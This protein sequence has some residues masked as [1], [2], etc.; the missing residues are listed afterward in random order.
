M[1]EK[2]FKKSIIAVAIAMI[3][4]IVISAVV[5]TMQKIGNKGEQVSSSTEAANIEVAEVK[6]ASTKIA[7]N[8]STNPDYTSSQIPSG[9][10]AKYADVMGEIA[11]DGSWQTGWTYRNGYCL[12]KG[13]SLFEGSQL[14]NSGDAYSRV[15]SQLKW[16]FD[17]MI[18]VFPYNLD[19]FNEQKARVQAKFGIDLSGL[20]RYQVF[21][22]QQCA[23]WYFTNELNTDFSGQQKDY[24]NALINGAQ[25]SYSSDG[26]VTVTANYGNARLLQ[27]T[28][29]RRAEYGPITISNPKNVAYKFSYS[30]FTMD[31]TARNVRVLRSDTGAE[32]PNNSYTTFSGNLYVIVDGFTMGRANHEYELKGNLSFNTYKTDSIYWAASG[33]QSVSTFTRSP[34]TNTISVVGKFKKE[35]RGQFNLNITKTDSDDNN[36]LGSTIKARKGIYTGN[37][38]TNISEIGEQ[39]GAIVTANDNMIE[40]KNKQQIIEISEITAPTGY[41]KL[42]KNI[43]AVLSFKEDGD[44]YVIDNVKIKTTNNNTQLED[45]TTI[46]S[47]DGTITELG[48]EVRID[49]GTGNIFSVTLTSDSKLDVKIVNLKVDLALKK[50]ITRV[51]RAG[52]S[53]FVNVTEENCNVGRHSGWAINT[54]SL[55]NSTN[56]LY[57][58][59]KTPVRVGKGDE[60]E[61]AIKI[62]NEGE[63]DGYAK[64]IYDYIPTGLEV[65]GVTYKNENNEPI[66][67][68]NNANSGAYATISENSNGALR[69]VFPNE[70]FI[71]AY[72]KTNKVLSSDV[73]YVTCRVK[74]DATGILTNVAEI[75]LYEFRN[76]GTLS[77]D[78]DSTANNWHHWNPSE[79]DKMTCDKGTE[80]WRKYCNYQDVLLDGKWHD[81]FSAQDTSISGK[82]GDD[83]DFDKLEVINVDLA[84]KKIITNVTGVSNIKRSSS[85]D[86]SSWV[87]TTPLAN[88]QTDALYNMNK[89]PILAKKGSEVT[90]RL[91]IFN[92]GTIDAKAAEIKDYIPVGLTVTGVYY[93]DNQSISEVLSGNFDGSNEKAYY[94]DRQ[95][96]VLKINLGITDNI[97][98]KRK[99]DCSEI[100]YDYV[101]VK[102]VINEQAENI[103]TNVAEISK[104]SDGNFVFSQDIDSFS[105][106]WKGV[107]DNPDGDS[108][109]NN[110]WKTYL[111]HINGTVEGA[112]DLDDNFHTDFK[113]S[114]YS[115]DGEEDDDDFEKVTVLDD[116]KVVVQKQSS[117]NENNKLEGVEFYI[118]Q[119][120]YS[121]AVSQSVER[122]SIKATNSEGKTEPIEKDLTFKVNEDEED[123]FYI[124]EVKVPENSTYSMINSE[125]ELRISKTMYQETR[126]VN[127]QA[128]CLTKVGDRVDYS[129]KFVTVKDVNGHNVIVEVEYDNA[130]KT[131]IITVP[132]NISNSN[133]KLKLLKTKAGTGTPITGVKF[134]IN[135]KQEPLTTDGNGKID[136]G[137]YEIT[138]DNYND[139]DE[140]IISEIED[141]SSRYLQLKNPIN[142]KVK[143]AL[144][145]TQENYIVSGISLNNSTYSTEKIE[146]QVELKNSTKKVKLSAEIQGNTVYVSVE[147][148]EK[149]GQYS[150][151]V[152]KTKANG[153]VLKTPQTGF[154]LSNISNQVLTDAQTGTALLVNAKPIT[155][156]T[157]NADTYTITET[158]APTGFAKLRYPIT[159][160]VNKQDNGENFEI[161]SVTVSVNNGQGV[162]VLKGNYGTLSNVELEDGSKIN[163]NI[164]LQ[165]NNQI[166]IVVPN[167]E[168]TGKYNIQ[169]YKYSVKNGEQIP[170]S[171]IGFF[172]RLT[173]ITGVLK[174]S[175]RTTGADGLANITNIAIEKAG[176]DSYEI[177]EIYDSESNV[178]GIATPI[179]FNVIK[180][181]NSTGTGYTVSDANFTNGAKTRAVTLVNG[182]SV[183]AVLEVIAGS[184]GVSTIKISIE[185]PQIV[186]RYKVELEKVVKTD[187]GNEAI[188]GVTFKVKENDGRA[189][190]FTTATNGKVF[191]TDK[192]I[193]YENVNTQDKY[194]IDEI[195]LNNNKYIKLRDPLTLQ[196]TKG[197]NTTGNV[198]EEGAPGTK[199]VVQQFTLSGY[200][201]SSAKSSNGSQDNKQIALTDIVL[202][203]GS[204]VDITAKLTIENDVLT[205]EK[206]EKVSITVP[207]KERKG[208]YSVKVK[209]VNA[210]KNSA[211]ISN[212]TFNV[213]K[214]INGNINNEYVTDRTGSNGEISLGNVTMTADTIDTVD[215]FKISEVKI[216]KSSGNEEETGFAKLANPLILSVNKKVNVNNF[217]VEKLTLTEQ[218]KAPVE[219]TTSVTL[220]NV[221]LENGETVNV[222]ASIDSDN[223]ITVVI[224]NKELG[225]SYS[226]DLVKTTD[227]FTNPLADINFK[228]T[229]ND[230][231]EKTDSNGLI[232]IVRNKQITK[233][234]V[235]NADTY[236]I[237]EIEDKTN[238]YLELA[239][240]LDVKVEKVKENNKFVVSKITL[241]SGGRNAV[242]NANSEPSVVTLDNIDTVNQNRKTSAKLEFNKTTQKITVTVDNP[243]LDGQYGL[244]ILKVDS[245][246]AATK[247]D[248]VVFNAKKYELNDSNQ[249]EVTADKTETTG[250]NGYAYI[251]G[252]NPLTTL[253]VESSESI[254]KLSPEKWEITET[255]TKENYEILKN[256]VVTLNITKKISDDGKKYVIDTVTPQ[257]TRTQHDSESYQRMKLVRGGLEVTVNQ[258]GTDIEVKIPNRK[259]KGSYSLSLLKVKKASETPISG[260]PFS[261]SKNGEEIITNEK[262][263]AEGVI[264]IGGQTISGVATDEYVV[265]EGNLA[266]NQ[267]IGLNESITVKVNTLENADKTKYVLGSATFND[268]STQKT[269]RT[270]KG[271]TV[272]AKIITD[273]ANNTVKLVVENDEFSGKYSVYLKKVVN[274]QGIKDVVFKVNGNN[275]PATDN[276]GMT[277]VVSDKAITSSTL[278]EDVYTISEINIDTNKYVKLKAPIVLRV[279]K[280][281][282]D[283]NTD[284]VPVSIRLE[285]TGISSEKFEVGK[286]SVELEGIALTND[287]LVTVKA[288]L[289]NNNIVVE[290]PNEEVNGGYSVKIKKVNADKNNAKIPGTTFKVEKTING[291]AQSAVVTEKTNTSAG[292]VQIANVT[293]SADKINQIDTYKVSEVKIYKS[294]DSNEEDTGYLKLVNPV[295]LSVTKGVSG[296]KFVVTN[297]KLEQQ[298]MQAVSGATNATLTGVRLESGRTVNVSASIDNNNVITLTVPNAE[299]NGKYSLDLIKTRNNFTETLI[300]FS[301][302]YTGNLAGKKT[303]LDGLV[304][305]VTDKT[306][307]KDDVDTPDEYEITEVKDSNNYYLEL[308]QPV[309]LKVEKT[310][311]ENT[312]VVNK[313]TISSGERTAT[314][315]KGTNDNTVILN[316]VDTVNENVKTSLKLV[317]DDT[318]NKITAY[319]DNPEVTGEYSLKIKKVDSQDSNR[320]LQ[321][322]T[323]KLTKQQLVEG[324][325]GYVQTKEVTKTTDSSGYAYLLGDDPNTTQVEEK[326]SFASRGEDLIEIT[327]LST[328]SGYDLLKDIKLSLEVKNKI[329]SDGKTK[330]I[331]SVRPLVIPSNYE[332]DTKKRAEMV[333]K[334]LNVFVNEAGTEISITLPNEKTTDYNFKVKKVDSNGDDVT[335]AKFTVID[336][337][338][339]NPEGQKL[340]DNQLLPNNSYFVQSYNDVN[341]NK[342]Y[343][344]SVTENSTPASYINLLNGFNLNVGVKIDEQG[345]VDLDNSTLEIEPQNENYDEVAYGVISDKILHGKIKI[346]TEDDD[347]TLTLTIENPKI[348]TDYSLSLYKSELNKEV[349]L[350]NARFN[351]EKDGEQFKTIRTAK[352]NDSLIDS[353]DGVEINSHFVYEVEETEAPGNLKL[354]YKKVRIEISTD[355]EG[356]VSGGITKVLGREENAEWVDYDESTHGSIVKLIRQNETNKFILKWSDSSRFAFLL[357]KQGYSKT[358]LGKDYTSDLIPSLPILTNVQLGI[359]EDGG[360]E[361]VVGTTTPTIFHK[362]NVNSNSEYTYSIRELSTIAGYNNDFDG[363]KLVVHIRTDEN[364]RLIEANQDMKSQYSYY[365][366]IDSTGNKTQDQLKALEAFIK[367]D[368]NPS[369]DSV[370]FYMVNTAQSTYTDYK[371]QIMKMD[372]DSHK[373]LKDA[374]FE[375]KLDK[376]DGNG[377]TLLDS[378]TNTAEQDNYKT[379]VNG[380]I[381]ISNIPFAQAT[382]EEQIHTFKIK[383]INAPAGYTGLG[384][385]VITVRVNLTNKMSMRDIKPEDVTI[386]GVED[387]DVEYRVDQDGW[388]Y[389]I[390]PNE[391]KSYN[392]RLRKMDTNGNLIVSSVNEQTGE[393]EGTVMDVRAIGKTILYPNTTFDTGELTYTCNIANQNTNTHAYV[394]TEKEAKN[395]YINVLQGYKLTVRALV[396]ENGRVKQINPDDPTDSNYTHYQIARD[397]SS[398]EQP[399]IA[400]EQISSYIKLYISEDSNGG[401]TVCVDVENPVSYMVRLRKTDTKDREIDQAI[402]N[403]CIVNGDEQVEKARIEGNS[404]AETEFVSIRDNETQ[405]WI[406]DELYANGP[407][408]N[409][410][411]DDKKL[412]VTAKVVNG[413]LTYDYAVHDIL[414]GNEVI[415]NKR[416]KIYNYIS[417]NLVKENGQN[418]I[419]VQIKNPVGYIFEVI[420]GDI[421]GHRITEAAIKVNDQTNIKEDGTYDSSVVI[422][423]ENVPIENIET[424][425]ISEIRTNAPYVNVLGDNKLFIKVYVNDEGKVEI[426]G[427]GYIDPEGTSHNGFGEFEQY[428]SIRIIT[429]A[430]TKVQTIEVTLK[431]PSQIRVKL[432]KVDENG[433]SLPGAS[434]Q[435]IDQNG[436]VVENNGEYTID[437][438]TQTERVFYKNFSIREIAAPKGYNNVFNNKELSFRASLSGKTANIGDLFVYELTES[439]R[440]IISRTDPIYE[441][442]SSEVIQGTDTL[443]G[444]P[445]ISFTI[446]NPTDMNLYI[447]K[448]LTNS[449]EYN[450]AELELYSLNTENNERTSIATNITNPETHAKKASIELNN[451]STLPNKTYTYVIKEKSTNAPHVNILE[452][453]EIRLNVKLSKDETTGELGLDSNYDIYDNEGNVLN[454]DS[455]RSYVS[456][457]PVKDE[458]TG[459]YTLKV[460]IKNPS[461]FKMKFAKTDLAGNALNGKAV[462]SINDVQN[463]GTAEESYIM[464]IGDTKTF[465]ISETSISKPFVNAL[466]EN[467][468]IYIMV[469]LMEDETVKIVNTYTTNETGYVGGIDNKYIDYKIVNDE[470]GIPTLDIKLKNPMEYKIRI[471]KQDMSETPLEGAVITAECE[472]VTYSNEGRDYIEIPVKDQK[473]GDETIVTIKEIS[474]KTNFDNIFEDYQ[475]V[476]KFKVKDDYTVASNGTQ[477]F[478][479]SDSGIVTNYEEHSRFFRTN[480]INIDENNPEIIANIF[481]KN[482]VKYDLKVVKEDLAGN[483]LQGEDLKLKVTKNSNNTK[484]NNG[485]SSIVFNE[486]YLSP[487]QENTYEIEELSTIA[488]YANILA[489]KKLTITVKV[490]GDG[491]LVVKDFK[492]MDK[493]TGAEETS[494]YVTYDKNLLSED[495][496]RLIKVVVKNPLS[497]MF[498]V[499]KTDIRDNEINKATISVNDVTNINTSVNP[500]AKTSNVVVNENDVKIGDVKR[501]YIT[502]TDTEKPYINVFGN[503]KLFVDVKMNEMAKL[504]ITNKGYIDESETVHSGFGQFNQYV[505]LKIDTNNQTK[506]QTVNVQ[507][508]NPINYKVKLVKLDENGNNLPNANIQIIHEGMD[509]YSTNG[510]D[511]IEFDVNTENRTDTF[512]INELD[513]AFGYNNNLKG[514]TMR[515]EV[516]NGSGIITTR[517]TLTDSARS[518]WYE[519]NFNSISD[520][521]TYEVKQSSETSDGVPVIEIKMKNT[522][523]YNLN[524]VKQ[525]TNNVAY[526]GAE[527]ELYELNT[528]NNERTLIAKNIDGET[529]LANITKNQIKTLP[530]EEHIYVIK[531]KSTTLPHVNILDDDKEIRVTMKLEKNDTTGKLR[532]N[533]DYNIY[534]KNGNVLA[535]DVARNFIS[536]APS[537]DYN[538]GKY[539]L[540]VY[541]KNP[542]QFRMR[543][544][545]TDTSGNPIT[546]KAVIAINGVQNNGTASE[547][548]TNLKVGDSVHLDVTETSVQD[549]FVNA[550]GNHSLKFDAT[551]MENEQI[552]VQSTIPA[553][554]A[555]Y[556]D[557][558]VVTDNDGVQ[559]LEIKLKNPMK[560]KVKLV[561]QDLAGTGLD[562]TNITVTYNDKV[563]KNNGTQFIEIPVAKEDLSKVD[564]FKIREYS[565][566]T[567]YEN[568]FEGKE[569]Q[570]K[571]KVNNQYK[572]E[573]AEPIKMINLTNSNTTDVP[574]QYFNFGIDNMQNSNEL[575]ANITLKNPIKY[576]LAVIKTDLSG[577]EISGTGLQMKVT[578]N[579]D[580]PKLNQGNST[581]KYEE[582]NLIPNTVNKY[583]VEELSTIAPHI[584]ELENKKLTAEVRVNEIGELVM[585]TFV[586]T[587]KTT[588]ERVA[589]QYVD[590]DLNARSADGTRLVKIFVRNPMSYKFKV[591]KTKTETAQDVANGTIPERLEGASIEVNNNSNV[592]GNSE[593]GLTINDVKV[594]ETKT[595]I[596]KENATVGAHE[597][598][599]ENKEI[600]LTTYMGIDKKL[601]IIEAKLKDTVSNESIEIN[602]K[603]KEQYRFDYEI[604]QGEDGFE[605][606]NV[607]IQNPVKMKMKVV[608]TDAT[609][610]TELAGAEL[611]LKLGNKVVASN[612]STGSSVLDY[613]INNVGRGD[614]FTCTLAENASVSPNEN[615]LNGKKIDISFKLNDSEEME[616]TSV[617]QIDKITGRM[618][619]LSKFVKISRKEI[620]GIQTLLMEVSNPV[621]FDLD[622][623]KNAAGLGFL[624]NTKFQVYREDV[625][626]SLFD[627][628]V[629]DFN[630][631]KT[632]EVSEHKLK[633]GTY[634]YYIT[635]TKSARERYINILE[636]KYIKLNLRVSGTGKVDV[637]DNNGEVSQKYFEVYEGNIADRK[638]TDKLIPNTDLIYSCINLKTLVN[639]E[640]NKYLIHVDVTNPVKYT[641]ELEKVD[642]VQNPLKDAEFEMVSDIINSQNALKTEMNKTVG[643]Q[644]ITADGKI[645]GKTNENGNVSY[646]ETYVMAGTYEYTLK[647]VKTPGNQYVNPFEGYTIHFKVSVN[648]DGDIELVSYENGRNTYIEKD[649][650]EAPEDIYSYL[651]LTRRNNEIIAKLQIE[652][653]NPVRYLVKLDKDVYGEENLPL[654]GAKF[655]IESGLIKN[656]GAEKT[657]MSETVGVTEVTRN[658][659][660]KGTTNA[661]GNISFEETM[662]RPGIYE[663]W[664]SEIETGDQDILNALQG[665]VIKVYLKVTSDGSIY[666]VTDDGQNQIIENGR[667][668]LYD[669]TRQNKIDFDTTSIDELI[670]VY[671]TKENAV[672]TLHVDIDNPQKFDFDLI[673]T[674]IDL[675]NLEGYEDYNMNDVEFDIKAYKENAEH[676]LDEIE[677][678][679]AMD[680]TKSFDLTGLVTSTI[681]DTKGMISLKDILIPSAG[682][683][684]LEFIEKTP[685]TPIIY[686][687]KAE[688]VK[689]K[690]VIGLNEAGNKYEIKSVEPVQGARYVINENTNVEDSLITVNV[691]NERVKGSYNL[692]I[693][694]L[695][696]LLGGPVQGAEFV[697]EAFEGVEDAENDNPE[698]MVKLYKSTDDVTSMD[699]LIPGK[700]TINSEDGIFRINKIRIENLDSYVI[701]ITETKAPETY[702]I[703]RDPVMLKI[704]PKI[705]GEYDDAKFVVDTVEIIGSDND[706]LVRLV[707][708]DETADDEN[709]EDT[710]DKGKKLIYPETKDKIKLEITNNQF[711]LSL[712]KYITS[713]NGKDISRWTKPEIDTSK[714]ITGEETTAEYY[715]NKL[716]LRI[717]TGQ[718]IIYTLRVY[719]EGQIDGYANKIV[720]HLPEQLEFLENDEFNTSRGWKLV[721]G[722]TSMIETDFLSKARNEDEN[723]IKAFDNKTGEIDYKEVQVKCKVKENVEPKTY[724]TNIAEITEFEGK[725]RPNV[726]DRDSNGKNADI[727]N[728]K[729]LQEYKQDEIEKQQTSETQSD[730]YISGQE[731]DDDFEKVLVERFDLALRKFITQVNDKEITTRIPEVTVDEKG[732]V[733]YK[734]DKTPLVVAHENL[735]EY[736]I[737]VYNE[738]TVS[739]YANLV[740][741]DIPAGLVFVPDAETNKQYKWKLLDPSGRET[742]DVSNAKYV[743]TDYLSEENGKVKASDENTELTSEKTENKN[744][745]KYFDSKTMKEPDYRD[746]KVVF[747]VNVPRR[748]DDI[749]INEAQISDDRDDFGEEVDDDDSVTDVWNEG[750]DD[751]D[752]EYIKVKYF[753][754]ALYKWVTEAIVTEDGKTTVHP[755]N[756]TQDD[757]SNMLNVAIKKNKVNDVTV[758]FKYMIKVENQG[759]LSGYAKEIKDHIPAGLKFVAEDN[760]EYGWEEQPDGTITN[761]CFE[762]TLLNEGDTAEVAVILTWINGENNL[763]LKTNYA[764][765]SKDYNDSNSHDID[766]STDNLTDIPREDDEDEDIV[767]LQ[768]RTG[769]PDYAIIAITLLGAMMIV[770]GGVFGIRK[771]VIK[772]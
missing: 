288:T 118:G 360:E 438:L 745:I 198:G 498:K 512:I 740:K 483:E 74:D 119:K 70:K 607:I 129:K 446:K 302:K 636:N 255:S 753:D 103:L 542:L 593:V 423:E 443:D 412:Y 215:T 749:I 128:Y 254:T 132:N 346:D 117:E 36:L 328:T 655:E 5:V 668:Y 34:K 257:V 674:D 677:L 111:K 448:Q 352:N 430:L 210:S 667:F 189:T 611:E 676:E 245:E 680:N 472:G 100:Y 519:N 266:N 66:Q 760:T 482:Q 401:Q 206:Y 335:G 38:V 616:I 32:V 768:I 617:A 678:R 101:T 534:D 665:N 429:N 771:F 172:T 197:K 141:E 182:E 62:F 235:G 304:N 692:E 323:F 58:M 639:N 697:I 427:K 3:L 234:N 612:K 688:N 422:Q 73:V 217:G 258:A 112:N 547:T 19:N 545:K 485:T 476:S 546:G 110:K 180:S 294:V 385:D 390:V 501:F 490:D 713:I 421:S 13:D 45:I 4:T 165:V 748:S 575:I 756:H 277:T 269:V 166:L 94:Y 123:V 695:E 262:T 86:I 722:E 558:K 148:I 242:L 27:N 694:K 435:I 174:G 318:N 146:Q 459:K 309:K 772:A 440:N 455:A 615:I 458:N 367:L 280:G 286:T 307:T 719:N 610:T 404:K 541:I 651:T 416:N 757:K 355:N 92:E 750:E 378:N 326:E 716:P 619:A 164:D 320:V 650:V 196:I 316:N 102:C 630:V 452:N 108:K 386:S 419:D 663:Y 238:N 717:Y 213:T 631:L 253:Q 157:L 431:N 613:T 605:T 600:I 576:D 22:V 769:I 239:N 193:N 225:G 434:L 505:K 526:N 228:Y 670:K 10:Y 273:T 263:N 479:I 556:V 608:K 199:F 264:D 508:I 31:G 496:T 633:A 82:Q 659:V 500:Q 705:E 350:E 527:L 93:K 495:G 626:N 39:S 186:G 711:D 252:D 517:D 297:L 145:N 365:E 728:G 417:V 203:D 77:Q 573:L 133:Y 183:N 236:E 163:V 623:A 462:I 642:S 345:K 564:V 742:T 599:L 383:E 604:V 687:D 737:R 724:I 48:R 47:P 289:T 689:V 736:T 21:E 99:N 240:K 752:R 675:Y 251:S 532:L 195:L 723:V 635:E 176:T 207:N 580:E 64:F 181:L 644:A 229:G 437:Y 574:S 408:S 209:K 596:V 415:Y 188:P 393:K 105:Q 492:V 424:Y 40:D 130:S 276:S 491:E 250:T 453:K 67:I 170:V 44:K 275:L 395:G 478:K 764:E 97:I 314:L 167:N 46:T 270:K 584:N 691:T 484:E 137:E 200:G 502:E 767:M 436:T 371:L 486:R 762:N 657:R 50:M 568:V 131:F 212:V 441:C 134:G 683:Y 464:N 151:M 451:I 548:Y 413:E 410:L 230:N 300:G 205:N 739:G 37:G 759:N 409:V 299:V 621:G 154:S 291:T 714:L 290:I 730:K 524:I 732:K 278:A 603:V 81:S 243:A 29:S 268:G 661:Q 127:M 520:Y 159:V 570:V 218:G 727:P 704:T 656:Q 369:A 311:E 312:Y 536:L 643:V 734:H 282:N 208:N 693:L 339:E 735:V 525:T 632:A 673:K 191:I 190:S 152:K 585:Q 406:I 359:S 469:R 23:V 184:N 351:V 220:N 72:D 272:N 96:N 606:V 487:L 684:Y 136:F 595:F 296:D 392:F 227:N 374:E 63:I 590:Y 399:V 347:K 115:I 702:T 481:L 645:T 581:I 341:I 400:R 28:N 11:I 61:Y 627:G 121:E 373:W 566:K 382:S 473:P 511:S 396:D 122:Q 648:Q 68:Y 244:K 402:V 160:V 20:D 284:Y 310:R 185:N 391:S 204:V 85:T 411:K 567:N 770:A 231:G 147:N 60:V 84:L 95:H 420:K 321:G 629:T 494:A 381:S 54:N 6:E 552:N 214:T 18:V 535:N 279:R 709:A 376:G 24:Y 407:Y 260:I 701:K 533:Y 356:N 766:S 682:T 398:G 550:L 90:Y 384:D 324:Q 368:V 42:S 652:V 718:E 281:L 720:D 30:N 553:E 216:Y 319:V 669:S 135:T 653:E 79:F 591:V 461:L 261:V 140:Y 322:V 475:I 177:T 470:N 561:K 98:S 388:I 12:K 466:G 153:E 403:A 543:F 338:V 379:D 57:T 528:T 432:N 265:T 315:V 271:T 295:T 664:I 592:S 256:V 116:Y 640:T 738:G 87:D 342:T 761:K 598:I 444:I 175:Y 26:D 531:E 17:N 671:V 126:V 560:Y 746:I 69:I 442:F 380:T 646:E 654:G 510:T 540:N 49:D 618:E 699:E 362:E 463:N 488:P 75:N 571:L 8:G 358:L 518:G 555:G 327:E 211:P 503:N 672:S 747:K 710:Q 754:L 224:P 343:N 457:E 330:V 497:Y 372:S 366:L 418:V 9:S 33:L 78:I 743:I 468:N 2:L 292:E 287:K 624:V 538:T 88:N 53:E 460:F 569:I 529:K 247:L 377:E 578:R 25:S 433:N 370:S 124:K 178:I 219:G 597:N 480:V 114:K 647:E 507:L 107:S 765:I 725:D 308:A 514:K 16:L 283:A 641:V 414:S 397:T 493:T 332:A 715:N 679:K 179:Q 506:V 223:L 43:F 259:I 755:S 499:T 109:N 562:G 285:G 325:I 274:G 703:L 353:V 450:G 313:I 698:G 763:G 232:S 336:K 354:N 649:G 158:T 340:L 246:N 162:T 51:K 89:T 577:N 504:E 544:T 222:S 41:T 156:D 139:V 565:S 349:K 71:P 150:L 187:S 52:T 563:Y 516:S 65:I 194:V 331:E 696:E 681:S 59:N 622:L 439:G 363:I 113:G 361:T 634:T 666:T 686:K 301:F 192:E 537:A 721:E 201:I 233:E 594:G 405:T 625:E 708:E 579:S 583:V 539:T 744:L 587:D 125:L 303:G 333:K 241:S 106:N 138:R 1:K 513:T 690:V 249:Y 707:A 226:L 348:T 465:K 449:V 144:D 55:E 83:D 155:A 515:I 660:V 731:D 221:Q 298:G 557:Y 364:A 337:N 751:Q 601:S 168:L 628:Y 76:K 523:D 306:I 202:E 588:G 700:F 467:T 522:T 706:G 329:A 582:R 658:G 91:Y 638:S 387:T 293:M 7:T 477:I 454:N 549:P 317:L 530:N 425:T 712:R 726:V 620:D 394:I 509:V 589:S 173:N 334:G 305:I 474:S 161:S 120:P 471:N 521:F 169:I 586:V 35:I 602:E 758:K 733:S 80:L 14:Y 456:I 375:V 171:G 389:V 614:I 344:F 729:E 662:A 741:D 554:V 445:V 572:L 104:Y 559:A 237:R 609:G 685:K 489:N 56:A 143:K 357:F 142:L 426:V 428:V 551:V 15:S 637:L 447:E 149:D 248:G 267:Y